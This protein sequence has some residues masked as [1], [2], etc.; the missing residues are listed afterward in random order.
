MP[1]RMNKKVCIL[2]HWFWTT[3]KSFWFNTL[4][5]KSE[6]GKRS[7]EIIIWKQKHN[8]NSYFG[9]SIALRHK[10]RRNIVRLDC[11]EFKW[12]LFESVAI[13]AHYYYHYYYFISICFPH[14]FFPSYKTKEKPSPIGRP[15]SFSIHWK[16]H[17]KAK[18]TRLEA[19]WLAGLF[20]LFFF[21]RFEN[22]VCVVGFLLSLIANNICF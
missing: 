16:N 17:K 8:K 20:L 2:L 15:L 9:L 12:M 5:E 6:W 22:D 21:I 18:C 11:C 4:M 14:Y 10:P 1:L 7:E 19:D 3:E 13:F